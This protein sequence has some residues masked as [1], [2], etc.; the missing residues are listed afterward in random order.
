MPRSGTHRGLESLWG[1]WVRL[2]GC[3]CSEPHNLSDQCPSYRLR[4]FCPCAKSSGLRPT[5]GLECLLPRWAYPSFI[6]GPITGQLGE[7]GES[8]GGGTGQESV[9]Q[10]RVTECRCVTG[11]GV[12]SKQGQIPGRASDSDS[13]L[14]ESDPKVRV[15]AA[16]GSPHMCWG[17]WQSQGISSPQNEQKMN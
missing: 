9:I 15:T 6:P 3:R 2:H 8:G 12:H 16:S 4:M 11:D 7:V 5:L 10:Q 14:P 13:P 1:A 17:C